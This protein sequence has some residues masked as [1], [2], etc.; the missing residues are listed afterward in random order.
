VGDRVSVEEEVAVAEADEEGYEGDEDSRDEEGVGLAGDYGAD[1]FGVSGNPDGGLAE[2]TGAGG[3]LAEDERAGLGCRELGVA[4]GGASVWAR[5]R[6]GLEVGD[7]LQ[8]FEA[9]V[10][11]GAGG[12][13]EAVGAEG[14]YGE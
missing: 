4:S 8:V 9:L 10:D 14:F 12:A 11:F 13:L 2:G 3:F 7:L 5:S 1:G 6:H